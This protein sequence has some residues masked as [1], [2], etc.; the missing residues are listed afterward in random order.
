MS[1]T[2][3]DAWRAATTGQWTAV[4]LP[5]LASGVVSLLILGFTM[6]SVAV[7]VG[8]KDVAV[9]SYDSTVA[10]LAVLATAIQ[11]TF[12]SFITSPYADIMEI[13]E[14]EEAADTKKTIEVDVSA[15]TI[16]ISRAAVAATAKE[17]TKADHN[18][19]SAAAAAA[20]ATDE[21]AVESTG[22]TSK[23]KQAARFVGQTL[24]FLFIHVPLAAI[25]VLLVGTYILGWNL[26]TIMTSLVTAPPLILMWTLVAAALS[27]GTFTTTES[28]SPLFSG[29]L[30]RLLFMISWISMLVFSFLVYHAEELAE[31]NAVAVQDLGLL[32]PLTAEG[33]L[34]VLDILTT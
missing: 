27:Y 11:T 5:A 25:Q 23:W 22:G 6:W 24:F 7:L 9:P 2:V 3:S 20:A 31:L 21:N 10:S 34:D 30:I 16:P 12:L 33:E 1:S 18:G 8:E 13:W 15:S 29:R 17:A 4:S 28:W 26:L 14:E 19:A 32:G